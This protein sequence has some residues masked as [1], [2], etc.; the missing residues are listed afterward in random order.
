MTHF[1]VVA[2]LSG[3]IVS[4]GMSARQD[5]DSKQSVKENL[6]N[7][8]TNYSTWRK[9]ALSGALATVGIVG[10]EGAD[11]MPSAE[12][13]S[14]NSF[15]S[16]PIVNV[17]NLQLS[18]SNI[19]EPTMADLNSCSAQFAAE[20]KI[21][22]AQD[23]TTAPNEDNGFDNALSG[24]T[25]QARDI[26][27]S[28]RE[29]GGELIDRSKEAF[30]WDS[31]GAIDGIETEPQAPIEQAD[32]P[33][34]NIPQSTI[35]QTNIP[36][37]APVT[38]TPATQHSI[39]DGHGHGVGCR[40]FPG[41]G[42][43]DKCTILSEED[44]ISTELDAHHDD[45]EIDST[46]RTEHMPDEFEV[47]IVGTAQEVETESTI[48]TAAADNQEAK[49]SPE[50]TV[51]D[52]DTKT[53]NAPVS[54]DN[55]SIEA[56]PSGSTYDPIKDEWDIPMAEAIEVEPEVWQSAEAK[57]EIEAKPEAYDSGTI[58]DNAENPVVD[59]TGYHV[60]VLKAGESISALA[61]EFY[62]ASTLAEFEKGIELIGGANGISSLEINGVH[63]GDVVY[64]PDMNED[65]FAQY[66]TDYDMQE[67]AADIADGNPADYWDGKSTFAPA[68]AQ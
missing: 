18:V 41:S 51:Y 23:E 68:L 13:A 56:I 38:D 67:L 66:A 22:V 53:W 47:E 27:N 44:S 28:A 20:D 55:I 32:I 59:P 54:N 45:H 24:M 64:I 65:N 11:L 34:E 30:D 6:K 62:G 5:W 33:Q 17:Q 48:D 1:G 52:P 7:T 2:G 10:A 31:M 25:D 57:P 21:A 49:L 29:A 16:D 42:Y 60:H 37:D 19:A 8:L 39:N 61:K 9:A 4:V 12:A 58:T 46:T 36:S 43:E 14:C 40:T 26:W 63:A 15:E 50:H 3:V 35:P